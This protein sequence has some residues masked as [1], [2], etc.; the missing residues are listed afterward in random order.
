MSKIP[1]LKRKIS[2]TGHGVFVDG[3]FVTLTDE[4]NNPISINEETHEISVANTLT[5]AIHNGSAFEYSVLIELEHHEIFDFLFHCIENHPVGTVWRVAAGGDCIFTYNKNVLVSE[6]GRPIPAS[7]FNDNKPDIM[8]CLAA[9]LN[10]TVL[11]LGNLGFVQ[12][13]PAGRGTM[14]G[15]AMGEGVIGHYIS[16]KMLYIMRMENISEQKCWFNLRLAFFEASKYI[17]T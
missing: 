8:P 10:P 13:F 5:T 2:D 3:G 6:K 11:S 12:Y 4:K 9:Y 15:G 7:R 1:I 17:K 16:P 14:S